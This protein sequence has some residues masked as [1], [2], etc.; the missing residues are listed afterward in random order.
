MA[1]EAIF[2]HTAEV[3]Q[4]I[5]EVESQMVHENEQI[6]KD[7]SKFGLNVN[8][9]LVVKLVLA[10]SVV[11]CVAVEL[12]EELVAEIPFFKRYKK[13]ISMLQ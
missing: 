12:F 10:L 3:E 8:G 1:E 7:F 2:E 13:T 4:D 11:W 9:K 5:H 6:L